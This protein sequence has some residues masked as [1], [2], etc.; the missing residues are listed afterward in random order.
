MAPFLLILNPVPPR[1]G[2]EKKETTTFLSRHFSDET[3]T[4]E[5][6]FVAPMR[7]ILPEHVALVML[8]MS[9]E[10]ALLFANA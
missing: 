3:D 10:Y 9:L 8:K 5:V 1:G 4:K 7:P 6:Q 2:S